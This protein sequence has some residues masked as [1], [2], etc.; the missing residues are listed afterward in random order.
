MQ[1]VFSLNEH[2]I[3]RFWRH[4]TLKQNRKRFFGKSSQEIYNIG[5]LISLKYSDGAI[6]EDNV[7]KC[8]DGSDDTENCDNLNISTKMLNYSSIECYPTLP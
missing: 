3:S 8:S 7:D 6:D 5:N 1:G 2:E 4:G